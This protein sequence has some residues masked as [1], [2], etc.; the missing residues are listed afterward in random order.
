MSDIGHCRIN[1]NVTAE[2]QVFPFNTIQT[3]RSYNSTL[4]QN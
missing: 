1:V 4:V 2:V 3:V